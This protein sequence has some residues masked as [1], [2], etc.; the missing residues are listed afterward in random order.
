MKFLDIFTMIVAVLMFI[1]F[2]IFLVDAWRLRRLR[3]KYK[4][5]K[6]DSR[7]GELKRRSGQAEKFRAREQ[8][9]ERFNESESSKFFPST[10]L[11]IRGE[12]GVSSGE[13]SNS[14][15]EPSKANQ[16]LSQLFG[17]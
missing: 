15:G 17:K 10:T 8:P 2:L 9:T 11:N 6:D 4:E 16:L 14:D 1:L 13:P 12:K 5:D 7:K 3:K